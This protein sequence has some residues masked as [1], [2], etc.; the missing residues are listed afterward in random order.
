MSSTDPQ[1]P[2]KDAT[3]WA[4][5]PQNKPET[6]QSSASWLPIIIITLLIVAAA[7][8]WWANYSYTSNGS[9][10]APATLNALRLGAKGQNSKLVVKPNGSVVAGH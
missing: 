2:L 4:K 6:V 7:W 5:R 8:W 9:K 10:V 1:A 3:E